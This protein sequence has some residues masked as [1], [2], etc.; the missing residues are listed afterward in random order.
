MGGVVYCPLLTERNSTKLSIQRRETTMLR[1]VHTTITLCIFLCVKF[2]VLVGDN[3]LLQ[4]THNNKY[5]FK[6][7]MVQVL[8][9]RKL[10]QGVVLHICE[11]S[12]HLQ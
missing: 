4:D 7:Y 6:N 3:K 8:Y 2:S 10:F 1:R 11:S 12:T 5:I 9:Y